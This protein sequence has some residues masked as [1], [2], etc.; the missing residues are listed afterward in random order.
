MIITANVSKDQ[1]FENEDEN[2]KASTAD[3]V[4]VI[5]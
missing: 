2:N 5:P 3:H 4:Q 1:L